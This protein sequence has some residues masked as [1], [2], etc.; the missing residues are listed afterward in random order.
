MGLIGGHRLFDQPRADQLQGFA[1]PG[2]LL[3]SVLDQLAGAEAEPQGAEAAAGID[4][5]QLPVIA[6]QHHLRVRVL[7]VLEQAGQLARA[8][9]AG[10]IHHHDGARIQLLAA[11]V[12]VGQEAV[13][14]GHVLEPLALQAH[15][16]DPVGA[17][18]RSR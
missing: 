16:R 1:F 8:D 15:G 13:A 11:A 6:D 5:G 7:G 12:Q 3:P 9:H 4:W 18:A 17:K 2:L 14:G 10:L